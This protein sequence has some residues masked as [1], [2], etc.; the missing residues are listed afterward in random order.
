MPKSSATS[1]A[2]GVFHPGDVYTAD[3][4]KRRTGWGS[5]AFAQNRRRG[6]RTKTVGKTIFVRGDDLIQFVEA[7]GNEE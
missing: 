3:E 1:D 2:P 6:L 5:W 7:Q 4:V